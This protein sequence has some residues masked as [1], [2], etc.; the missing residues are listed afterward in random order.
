MRSCREVEALLD[1]RAADIQAENCTVR[2]FD[3]EGEL[4]KATA[5]A[6]TEGKV[7]GWFQGPM[8]FGPRAL[9]ARSII[10]DARSEAMQSVMNLKMTLP[11]VGFLSQ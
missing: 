5:T 6:I 8:E 10:G 7:I 9:G 4:C 3:D 1:S 11:M 2:R